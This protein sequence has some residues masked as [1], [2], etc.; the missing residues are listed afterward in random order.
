MQL[1]ALAKAGFHFVRW[2]GPNISTPTNPVLPVTG[3]VTSLTYRAVFAVG[4]LPVVLKSFNAKKQ[5]NKVDVNWETTSETNNDYFVVERSDNA[6]SWTPV[7]T[8]K[9]SATTKNLQQYK[10]TDEQPLA[11]INYY[12]LKQVDFDQTTTYSRIVSVDMDDFKIKNL[13]PNPATDI[14]NISLDQSFQQADYEITD[15]NGR[16]VRKLQKLSGSRPAKISVEN[17]PIGHYILKIKTVDGAIR[18]SKFVKQ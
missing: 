10:I 12:R 14:L 15:V 1:T 6:M 17:L 11:G 7:T 4:A 18:A 3:T 16:T 5:E 8:V 9:G 2:E 13:W